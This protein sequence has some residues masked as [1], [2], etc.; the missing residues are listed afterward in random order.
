MGGGGVTINREGVIFVYFDPTDIN[1][2]KAPMYTVKKQY[3]KHFLFHAQISS[4]CKMTIA[5][6]LYSDYATFSFTNNIQT[7]EVIKA[8]WK[9]NTVYTQ[10]TGFIRI[11]RV[12]IQNFFLQFSK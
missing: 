1:P 7:F 5:T 4:P 9:K 12:T 2:Q 8:V 3:K 6:I 11:R 10:R